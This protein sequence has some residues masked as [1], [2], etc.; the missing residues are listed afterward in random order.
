VSVDYTVYVGPWVL[1]RCGRVLEA[2][3]LRWCCVNPE[4]IACNAPALAE[5]RFCSL[6]GRTLTGRQDSDRERDALDPV[7]LQER[8]DDALLLVRNGG[9]PDSPALRLGTH[10]WLPNVVRVGDPGRY[11]HLDPRQHSVALDLRALPALEQ[12]WLQLEYAEQLAALHAAYGTGNVE[13]GWGVLTYT[14]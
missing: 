12:G 7:E 11:A 9:Q 14:S 3:G 5:M 10:A 4:C 13:V 6:C 2:G 1:C 8:F